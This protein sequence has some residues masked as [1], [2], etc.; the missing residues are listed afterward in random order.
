MT[1]PDIDYAELSQS[2]PP[3]PQ[4]WK[5]VRW[6]NTAGIYAVGAGSAVLWIVVLAMRFFW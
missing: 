1:D 5:V 6:I 4:V 2:Y 3:T